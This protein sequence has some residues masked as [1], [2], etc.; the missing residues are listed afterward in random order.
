MRG[1]LVGGHSNF[2]RKMRELLPSWAFY[3]AENKSVD[4]SLVRNAELLVLFTS[5]CNHPLTTSV[6]RLARA[7]NLALVYAYKVNPSAFVCEVVAK[8]ED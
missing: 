3:S 4:E 8:L 5:H 2:H 7:D 6:L 1:V